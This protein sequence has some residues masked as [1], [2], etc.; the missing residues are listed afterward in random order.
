[1]NEGFFFLFKQVNYLYYFWQWNHIMME[2]FLDTCFY[3]V[4]TK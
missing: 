1:M 3:N 4:L 2:I